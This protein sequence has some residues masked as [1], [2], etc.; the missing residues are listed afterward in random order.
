VLESEGW[1]LVEQPA[2][3]SRWIP[4]SMA[5]YEAIVTQRIAHDGDPV[6]AQHVANVARD[7]RGDG[8]T[9]GKQRHQPGARPIDAA[10]ACAMAAW[11]AM[12][13][14]AETSDPFALANIS[15]RIM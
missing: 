12:Q 10:M 11:G 8:W 9:M 2:V 6:L 7:E 3:R 14:Q 1:A 15:G 5:F 4:I 13:Y